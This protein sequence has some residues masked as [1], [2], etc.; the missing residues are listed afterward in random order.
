MAVRGEFEMVNNGEMRVVSLD[1]SRLTIG[2]DE[3]SDLCLAAPMVSRQHAEVIRLGD[4]FLLRDHGS[5]NG[6]YVNETRISERMLV[7]GDLVRFGKAGPELRFHLVEQTAPLDDE[8]PPPSGTT[9]NLVAALS[10]KLDGSTAD[11]VEEANLR[12]LLADTY[13]RKGHG[14]AAQAVLAKYSGTVALMSLPVRNRAEVQRRLGKVYNETKQYELANETLRSSI[15]LYAQADDQTGLAEAHVALGRTLV[16]LDDML[17]ARDHLHRATLIARQTGNARIRA[18]THLMLGKI[19]WKESD[20]DGARYNWNRAARLAEG[21]TDEL[22]KALVTLQLAFILYAEGDLKKAI[23]AYQH[24]IEQVEEIGNVRILLKAFSNLSRVLTRAGSWVATERLLERR[25]ALARE[26]V[27][28][29]AEAVALTD[30]AE[31][32][33]L[34]GRTRAASK[35]I[36]TAV[37]RHGNVTYARTQRI[38]GRVLVAEGRSADAVAALEAGL[39]TARTN[40]ALEEQV[41]VGLELAL[42]HLGTGN[43]DRAQEALE[44]AESTTTLDPALGLIARVRFTRAMILEARGELAE[45]N[46]ALAQAMS[47]FSTIGDPYRLAMCHLALG[48]LRSKLGRP[49][50]GRAH[51]E[52]AREQFA[53]LGATA[54]L[55]HVEQI[56]ATPA[57][58]GVKPSMTRPLSLQMPKIQTVESTHLSTRTVAPEDSISPPSP[59]RVL[60]AVSDAGLKRLL[61]RGLE[62]ENY[63]VDT[64]EHGRAALDASLAVPRVYDLLLLD[65]LLEH[66]SGFDVCR[67]LRRQKTE[68]PTILLGSRAGIEDKIEALQVG[69]DDYLYQQ[70][71]VFEEL[72]AKM[73]ALLR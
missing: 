7:D 68:T 50:S 73:E 36:A 43:L 33:L 58:I 29:K 37:E 2:R 59:Y 1:T 53:T 56:L 72:L 15:L 9:E 46:R 70:G 61:N 44:A 28:K 52:K 25:L 65:A 66:M 63:L 3:T 23:P 11:P 49:E 18:E 40:G 17:A 19:D 5:T 57:F 26:H 54:D 16:G 31:L 48:E 35:V 21:T 34:Q 62:V 55:A 60:L 13:L 14:E 20:L 41:L 51:L 24:A 69:A 64:V 27:L 8:P 12:C 45:A 47:V 39:E 6:S 67:E 42:A 71:F 38:L 4:D 22:L 32:R 30:L 10:E